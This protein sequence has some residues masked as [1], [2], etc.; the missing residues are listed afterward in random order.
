MFLK[1][2]DGTEWELFWTKNDGDI[3][4]Q[5]GWK[6]FSTYYSL[7]HGHMVLFEYKHTSHLDVHIFD[8]STLEIDYPFHCTQDEQDNL[9][10]I[11]D[12]DSVKISDELPACHKNTQKS[13]MSSPQPCKKLRTCTSKVERSSTLQ[14]LPQ[15]VQIEGTIL[16]KSKFAS[17]KKEPDENIGGTT[18][19][20]RVK[21]FTSKI[22]AIKKAKTFRSK[23]P[24]FTVV[25]KPAYVDGYDLAV[26]VQ[27]AEIYLKKKERNILLQ[28][29][30]GR[31]WT[32]KY[33]FPRISSRWKKF[34]TDN[35][36]KVGDVCL[37]E[38]TNIRDLSLK[39]HIF[40]LAEESNSPSVQGALK[41]ASEF[42]SENPSFK[43]KI[44]TD[45]KFRPDVPL[46][47]MRDYFNNMMQIVMLQFGKKLWPVKLVRYK[48]AHRNGARWKLV[49][50]WLQ[51]AR[52][53]KLVD[54]DYWVFELI[55]RENAVL[56]V[57][58]F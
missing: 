33:R 49:N 19:F 40:P 57:H 4:L 24:S 35:D 34:V 41:E 28:V 6:E 58:I 1:P 3:W 56:N 51:F 36:L 2:E 48:S 47:F 50:G 43:V 13:P 54:G 42:A 15:R 45:D 8:K 32:C 14:N 52:E 21:Q 17:V 29:L 9:D 46:V 25:M 23:S 22:T 11:S 16:E 26:P 18:E 5:K 39:V 20:L 10:Q 30:D 31:T 38:M 44:K 55:N 37:F 7:D 53:S 27:F 12:D